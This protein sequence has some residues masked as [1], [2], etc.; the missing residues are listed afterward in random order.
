[1]KEATERIRVYKAQD[2]PQVTIQEGHYEPAG[3]IKKHPRGQQSKQLTLNR[4]A[5]PKFERL[6]PGA[7]KSGVQQ[8]SDTRRKT[9]GNASPI[10]I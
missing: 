9:T 8:G 7:I 1:M 10:N 5:S 3:A 4:R 6:K 2:L